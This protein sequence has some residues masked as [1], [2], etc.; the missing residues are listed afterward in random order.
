MI[1]VNTYE[2]K[3]RS[4]HIHSWFFST[5]Q[6]FYEF[7][8]H[9]QKP[10][11]IDDKKGKKDRPICMNF[12]CMLKI[13]YVQFM[14]I[15]ASLYAWLNIWRRKINSIYLFSTTR[16]CACFYFLGDF[17]GEWGINSLK[18]KIIT[19]VL[20]WIHFVFWKKLTVWNCLWVLCVEA[21]K[22]IR[23]GW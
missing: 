4:I 12:S 23:Y 20:F 15:S 13:I 7:Y 3:R 2:K 8:H 17:C 11:L 14:Y 22:I 21:W 16:S 5:K 1:I 19:W 10:K 6:N 18:V 9:H